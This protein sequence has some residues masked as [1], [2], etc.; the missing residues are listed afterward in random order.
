M[1]ARAPQRRWCPMRD[2]PIVDRKNRVLE[3]RSFDG[4][5]GL[6]YWTGLIWAK[7]PVRKRPRALGWKPEWQREPLAGADA[8]AAMSPAQRKLL[9]SLTFASFGQHQWPDA[10]ESALQS[11]WALWR[12]GYVAVRED[13]GPDASH[14]RDGLV[15][16][17]T[18]EGRDL[19]TLLDRA[20][21]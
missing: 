16:R 15:V 6:A 9:A 11:C 21:A 12:R 3:V 20:T 7:A 19:L 17:L 14:S 8:L 18:Q 2:I 13:G 1:T 10:P 5:T 4:K